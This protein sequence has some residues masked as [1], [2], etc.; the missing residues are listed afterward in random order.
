VGLRVEAHVEPSRKI[1]VGFDVLFLAQFEIDLERLPS[2]R[3]EAIEA[4]GI[5]VCPARKAEEFAAKQTEV[6]IQRD[7]RLVARDVEHV[8]HGF[9]P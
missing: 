8:L 1:S 4:C 2:F 3:L 6:W 5:E 9:T 7:D